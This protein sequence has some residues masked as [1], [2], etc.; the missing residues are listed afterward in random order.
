MKTARNTVRK[1]SEP[2]S[3]MNSLVESEDELLLS[4]NKPI[5]LQRS[6]RSVS[7]PREDGYNSRKPEEDNGREF[8]RMKWDLDEEGVK[9]PTS[10]L[11]TKAGHARTNSEPSAGPSREAPRKRAGTASSNNK[12]KSMSHVPTPP[13]I[14]SPTG[15][16]GKTRARSVPLFPSL[17]SIPHLDFRNPPLSPIRARSP[18]PSDKYHGLRVYPSPARPSAS[19][20]RPLQEEIFPD[21]PKAL[22]EVDEDCSA[23]P[24][25]DTDTAMEG[26]GNGMVPTLEL[27]IQHPKSPTLSVPATSS[28]DHPI[29]LATPM[30][31]E[32]TLVIS[33]SP[34]TPLPPTPLPTKSVAGEDGGRYDIG[35]GWGFDLQKVSAV[36]ISWVLI[37]FFSL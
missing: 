35:D 9:N 37:S 25:I 31:S 16:L 12:P 7:P 24:V 1:S 11:L 29:G 28:V 6:K 21:D 17:S 2:P 4:P 19:E 32:P 34:L 36:K 15:V 33:M 30:P 3:D 20:Q 23:P 5:N 10:V 14:Q 8:K 13:V 18:C 27:S 22:M 26:S